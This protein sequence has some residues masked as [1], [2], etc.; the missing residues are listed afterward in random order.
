M[1]VYDSP[2][3]DEI[4]TIAEQIRSSIKNRTF[5]HGYL[6][7]ELS[8]SI[9]IAEGAEPLKQLVDKAD[10]AMRF[11]VI[12]DGSAS[13]TDVTDSYWA[14]HSIMVTSAGIKTISPVRTGRPI[15][16]MN[17]FWVM[18]YPILSISF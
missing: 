12:T 9:G 4:L 6:Q 14:Y 3:G 7:L 10:T 15:F 16:F 17:I 18:L 2:I 8:V 5:A 1:I 11:A 13:F